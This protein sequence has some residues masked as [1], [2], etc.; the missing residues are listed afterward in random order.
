[1]SPDDDVLARLLD[2]ARKTNQLLMLA[3]STSIAARISALSRTTAQRAVIAALSDGEER[4]TDAVVELA[5]RAG[6]SRS[7]T[8]EALSEL[9]RAG[10]LERPRRGAIAI[11][12]AARP[13]IT[14]AGRA[15]AEAE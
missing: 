6:S 1:M 7:P 3:Y 13:F 10:V 2:E 12:A 8:F 9:Q 5:R 4:T 14:A 11:T 15:R